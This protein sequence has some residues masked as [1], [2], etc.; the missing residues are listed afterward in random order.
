MISVLLQIQ[1]HLTISVPVL[2][3]LHYE[4]MKDYIS[5]ATYFLT[6]CPKKGCLKATRGLSVGWSWL[7]SGA[8]LWPSSDNC[9]LWLTEEH[10]THSPLSRFR[11]EQD[12]YFRLCLS[13][14]VCLERAERKLREGS[15]SQK[16]SLSIY[17]SCF[18][19]IFLFHLRCL[20]NPFYPTIVPARTRIILTAPHP[21]RMYNQ[22]MI[23]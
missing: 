1:K 2:R 16:E 20:E 14:A 12:K 18:K 19:G 10:R 15:R 23:W 3:K 7:S 6:V 8:H 4:V 22:W 13:D 9:V 21:R 11:K 5:K 17:F